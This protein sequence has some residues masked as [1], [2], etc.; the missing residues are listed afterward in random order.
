MPTH[1]VFTIS[2]LVDKDAVEGSLGV[3]EVVSNGVVVDTAEILL[4]H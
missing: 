2:V 3:N 1:A 4:F